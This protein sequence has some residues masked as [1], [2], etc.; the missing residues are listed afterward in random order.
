[1]YRL[2]SQKLLFYVALSPNLLITE[3]SLK[4]RNINILHVYPVLALLYGARCR[5]GS[6][7]EVN[8][9]QRAG[10]CKKD[11]VK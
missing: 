1:M 4:F 5:L 7:L 6:V 2:H 11:A 9:T 8:N 10:V 3:I